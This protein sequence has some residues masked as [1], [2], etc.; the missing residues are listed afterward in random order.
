MLAVYLLLIL[1][2]L[3]S[4]AIIFVLLK[5][6]ERVNPQEQVWQPKITIRPYFIE[7]LEDSP[8]YT[9]NLQLTEEIIEKG[10][11]F[12]IVA[13]KDGY[14]KL[15]TGQGWIKLDNTIQK[16]P[17]Y[18]QIK[19]FKTIT[20]DICTMRN[21]PGIGYEPIGTIPYGTNIEIFENV[22]AWYKI[23]Y[24]DSEGFIAKFYCE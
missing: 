16:D 11:Y 24:K 23:R 18:C 3:L 5:Q 15:L 2:T 17:P 20:K 21:G 8:L 14:G 6:V 13:E 22:G 9:D 12:T 7:I 4:G 10:G 19:F 1:N